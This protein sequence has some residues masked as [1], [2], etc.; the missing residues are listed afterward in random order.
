MDGKLTIEEVNEYFRSLGLILLQISKIEFAKFLKKRAILPILKYHGHSP[1][2][3]EYYIYFDVQNPQLTKYVLEKHPEIP[4]G[5]NNM[6]VIY[7][8]GEM[9]LR[10]SS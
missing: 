8:S 10:Y 2:V 5:F 9:N 4:E 3:A 1:A 7:E 6:L